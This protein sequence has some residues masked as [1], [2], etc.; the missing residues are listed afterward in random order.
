MDLWYLFNILWRKRWLIV[1]VTVLTAASTWIFLGSKAESY[2]A[3]AVISTGII[4]YKGLTLQKEGSFVQQFQIESSFN[5][6]IEQMK[7]RSTLNLLTQRLLEHDLGVDNAAEPPFRQPDPGEFPFPQSEIDSIVQKLKTNLSDSINEPLTNQPPPSQKLA[8]AF[9]YDYQTLSEDL[10]IQRVGESDLVSVEYEAEN[11]RLAHFVVKTFV[12]EFF[13]LYEEDIFY[14]ENVALK[15]HEEQ[16]KKRRAE[17][18]SI[19]QLINDYKKQNDLIDPNAQRGSI[20]SHL[21]ELESDLEDQRKTATALKAQIDI[22]N[23]KVQ[24]YTRYTG[25]D[26]ADQLFL[27]EDFNRIDQQIK[28]LQD[29]II[30]R[31]AHGNRNTRDLE[32]QIDEL[33]RKQANYIA[34]GVPLNSELRQRVNEQVR[35]WI[36]E[37]VEKKLDLELANAA[38]DSYEAEIQRQRQKF[39]KLLQDDSYLA[40]LQEEK[41]RVEKE[42]LRVRSDYDATRLRAEG[43]KNPLALVEPVEFPYEPEPSKRALFTLFAGVAGGTLTAVL[44]FLLAFID[45]TLQNAWRFS[46]I[47]G[48]PLIGQVPKVHEPVLELHQLFAKEMPEKELEML[49]ESVRKLRSAIENQ[50]VHQVLFTSLKEGEGKTFLTLMT[51]YALALKEKKVLVLDTNFRNNDLSAYKDQNTLLLKTNESLPLWKRIKRTLKG[52]AAGHT[53]GWQDPVLKNIHFIGNKGGDKSPSEVF[54]NRDFAAILKQYRKHYDYVLMESASV[55]DY[56]DA[57][58]LLPYV[59]KVVAVFSAEK[60]IGLNDKDA[61]DW[62]KQMDGKLLGCVLNMVERNNA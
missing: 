39:D 27:S 30:E 9:G 50:G 14:E 23:R 11:P 7:S 40:G 20:V 48:L 49:K 31:K 42:Y 6:L 12:E 45:N 8:E 53:V 22:L 37:T 57:G 10:K 41:D 5:N 34:Q 19:V 61:L 15:F 1:L 59:E 25:D 33:R 62:M 46:Q 54:A 47:V 26:Y 32:S 13:K 3:R 36:M 51:A 2:K 55:N 18:D 60:S 52:K 28:S 44:L 29:K 56:S 35:S 24:Q 38:I 43:L 4:E 17:L 58:E 16:L 21:K